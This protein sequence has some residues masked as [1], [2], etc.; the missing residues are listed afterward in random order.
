MFQPVLI[1][2]VIMPMSPQKDAIKIAF[3]LISASLTSVNACWHAIGV[4]IVT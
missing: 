4:S 2:L 3:T 1:I